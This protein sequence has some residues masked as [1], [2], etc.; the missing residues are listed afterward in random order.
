MFALNSNVLASLFD[1][2]E[3]PTTFSVVMDY[4]SAGDL[5]TLLSNLE[6]LVRTI[7]ACVA[8]A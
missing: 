8:V 5:A 7:V 3:T 4:Y 1:I 6:Y 2:V